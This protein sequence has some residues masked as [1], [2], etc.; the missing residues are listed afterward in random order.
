[1]RWLSLEPQLSAENDVLSVLSEVLE[2][3]NSIK[4]VAVAILAIVL[5]FSF[6]Y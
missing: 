4:Q 3:F 5:I 1:L 6:S 2:A